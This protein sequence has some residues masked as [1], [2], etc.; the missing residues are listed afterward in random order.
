MKPTKAR[1]PN[2]APSIIGS[3]VRIIGNIKTAGELQLDGIV[4]GDIECG[5]ITIGEHGAIEGSVSAD[6]LVVRGKID[7]TIRARSVRLEKSAKI[8]GD[9]THETLSVEAGARVEGRFV[10]GSN[11]Y[12]RNLETATAPK[13]VEEKPT[14]IQA[15]MTSGKL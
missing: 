1:T 7:G 10:H 5:A 6:S 15:A 4:E 12:E 14:N 3:D 11:K 2:T 8:T 9:V 13:V